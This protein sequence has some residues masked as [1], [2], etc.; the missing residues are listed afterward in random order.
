MAGKIR[1]VTDSSAQFLDPSFVQRHGIIVVPLTL[2]LGSDKLREG[3]DIKNEAFFDRV[4]KNRALV[5]SV[6]APTV[7][8]F[9]EVYTRLGFE[10]DRIL[11]IHMT[12]TMLPTWQN[13]KTAADALLGRSEIVAL[14]SQTTSVGLALLVEAAARL[15]LETDSL[16]DV[17]RTVRKLIPRIYVIFCVETLDYLQRGGLLSESQAILG[18]ML[19]IKPFLTIEEGDLIAM[20]KVRTRGQIVDKFVEFATEFASIDNL[21]ILQNNVHPTDLTRQLQ[22]RLTQEFSTR[23]FPVAMYNASL[24]SFIG[25]DAMGV[26]ILEGDDP[27]EFDRDDHEGTF[28]DFSRQADR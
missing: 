27:D 1:I 26:V 19:G 4:S 18:A 8:Q 15:A 16:D 14:D 12:R 24:C 7:E 5:P 22:E 11:S 23:I 2:H 20:E 28:N 3:A 9:A 25:P 21:V 6:S 13:A 10:T 17:V